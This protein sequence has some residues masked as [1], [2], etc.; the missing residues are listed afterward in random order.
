[1]DWQ[2]NGRVVCKKWYFASERICTGSLTASLSLYS[3]SVE[4]LLSAAEAVFLASKECSFYFST[5]SAQKVQAPACFC[6]TTIKA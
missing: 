3:A 2:K 1:M 6:R 5:K 4:Y